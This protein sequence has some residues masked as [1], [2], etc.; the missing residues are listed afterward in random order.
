MDQQSARHYTDANVHT[1]CKV[2]KEC[3]G[4]ISCMHYQNGIRAKLSLVFFPLD[5]FLWIIGSAT[6][7]VNG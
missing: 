3:D 5:R 7:L 1:R 6:S 2:Q 4:I